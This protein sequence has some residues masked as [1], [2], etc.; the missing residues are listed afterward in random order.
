M[1]ISD[2]VVFD[3]SIRVGLGVDEHE[4]ARRMGAC[5]VHL[6]PYDSVG[7]ELTVLETGACGVANIITDIAAPPEYAAPFS[8][9]VPTVARPFNTNGVR[10][11]I[12]MASRSRRSIGCHAIAQSGSGWVSAESTWP[13]LTPGLGPCAP[14]TSCS[15]P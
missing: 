3:R 14:G 15:G 10:G 2:Q 8:V 11:V 6:L 4:L 1:G 13:A 12:D 7:W 5:D 9:L